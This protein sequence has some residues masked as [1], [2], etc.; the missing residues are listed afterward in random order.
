MPKMKS[1]IERITIEMTTLETILKGEGSPGGCGMAL[2]LIRQGLEADN[3]EIVVE[4][5][6][7]GRRYRLT[8]KGLVESRSE[9]ARI[10]SGDES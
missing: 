5:R 10:D 4:D 9:Q 7:T 8:K 2:D 1:P 3:P 6:R